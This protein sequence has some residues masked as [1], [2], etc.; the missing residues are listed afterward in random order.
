MMSYIYI[1]IMQYN[2]LYI[3]TDAPCFWVGFT[4]TIWG[5]NHQPQ[6]QLYLD[7]ASDLI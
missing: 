4:N 2:I 7:S 1:Y 3:I 6:Q 5:T